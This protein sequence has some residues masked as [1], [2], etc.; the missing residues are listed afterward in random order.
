MVQDGKPGEPKELF[1]GFAARYLPTGHIV[2]E[3][4][5]IISVIPFNPARLEVTGGAVGVVDRVNAFAVSDAGMLVY[6]QQQSSDTA[7]L[8]GFTLVWVDREG[9]EEPIA[10][11]PNAYVSPNI[12]PDGTRVALSVWNG[13]DRTFIIHIWDLAR[14]TM[15]RLTSGE[16]QDIQSI[17]TP[18]GKRFLMIKPPARTVATPPP[19][20][21]RPK[22]NIVLNWFEEL[23]QQVPVK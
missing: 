10:A 21:P 18:D 19:P 9:K 5:N 3:Q 1:A 23:K 6:T 22:I 2:Y 16:K 8:G 12:S 15:S 13:G 17:W 14:E 11:P 4:G 7:G 20:A